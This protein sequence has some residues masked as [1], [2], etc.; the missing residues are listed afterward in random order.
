MTTDPT[1]P[2]GLDPAWLEGFAADYL[3]AWNSHDAERLLGLI[4][5]DIV[6]DDAAWPATMRG[7][8]DV[9]TFLEHTWR[10][11]PDLT[12]ELVEGPYVRPDQPKAAFHWR[13]RATHT[14]LIDPPGFAPT[15]RAVAFEGVD[16]HEYRDGRLARLR[17]AFD[18]MD[19]SR[20]LG[21]LPPAGSAV[22]RA[23]AGV[24]RVGQMVGERVRDLG[25]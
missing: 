23:L 13:A 17:I 5:D 21:L 20:Q 6:Y 7:H 24:Q 14:G 25:R 1:T 11:F 22:E 9:R 18:M 8:A 10:A 4:A 16:L 15:G 2:A 3:A 12:F 19:I